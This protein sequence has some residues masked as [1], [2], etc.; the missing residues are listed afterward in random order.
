M[1]T[2]MS[3]HHSGPEAA[4]QT[5]GTAPTV[6]IARNHRRSPGVATRPR[7]ADQT[8][9]APRDLDPLGA[10]TMVE[11]SIVGVAVSTKA[12]AGHGVRAQRRT[13]T[14]ASAISTPLRSL[15]PLMAYSAA[16]PSKAREPSR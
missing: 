8:S 4:H 6:A 7:S 3:R 13:A 12:T 5:S 11:Y 15:T 1:V 16:V 9:N 14:A 10:T 2:T